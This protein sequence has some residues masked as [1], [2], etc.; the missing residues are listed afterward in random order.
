MTVACEAGQPGKKL[1][2]SVVPQGI[3][4]FGRNWIENIP[5]SL[6]SYDH[7]TTNEAPPERIGVLE[8]QKDL[9]GV[10]EAH[11]QVFEDCEHGLL[12]ACKAQMY[13]IEDP[14]IFYKVALVAYATKLKLDKKPGQMLEQGIIKPVIFPNMPVPLLL[15]TNLMVT[16]ASA[17]TISSQRSR[18]STWNNTPFRHWMT[19]SKPYK[20]GSSSTRWTCLMPITRLSW[21][22]T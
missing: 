3:N 5:L 1:T 14:R 17:A 4:F 10:L 22:M 9:D 8:T 18:C 19:W 13:Q 7:N 15:L 12:T 20:E 6:A 2:V 11:S 21:R 16:S